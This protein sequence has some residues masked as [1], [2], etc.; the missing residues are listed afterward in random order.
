MNPYPAN[1]NSLSEPYYDASFVTAVKRFF[2]RWNR[3]KGR[4]SRSEFWWVTL[5]MFLVALVMQI[6]A[7][8]L[9]EWEV[10]GD[11]VYMNSTAWFNIF[12]GLTVLFGLVTLVP[13]LAL[14]WRRLHDAGFAGP[15]YFIGF[16]PLGGIVL[17]IM[18]LMPS[19]PAKMK[20]EWD[21]RENQGV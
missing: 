10:Q 16:I 9:A 19:N 12:Y 5:F 6:A 11:A 13:S 18:Y 3:F 7:F 2:L 15:W 1:T 21:D 20:M 17:F 14:T 8:V 4:S